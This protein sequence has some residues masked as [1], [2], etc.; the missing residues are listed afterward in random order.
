VA[1]MLGVAYGASIGGVA[2]LVGSPPNAVFAG[3][4]ASQLGV[5]VSFLDWFAVGAPLSAVL[6]VVTWRLLVWVFRPT[7]PDRR[8]AGAT[9][10]ARRDSLGPVGPGERRTLTVFALVAGG[11]LLRPFVLEP[12]FPAVTDATVG[13]VGGVLLFVVRADGEPLLRW[14]DTARLPW[15]VLVLLGAGF[16]LA[17]GFRASGLDAVV[18]RALAGLG[19]LPTAA[20]VV[21]VATTVVFLTEVTSNTATATVFMPIAASLGLALGVSPLVLMAT[22]A[23]A[24]SLAF[25]LP[26]AT[27][28]N[29]VVFAS[30]YVT[31]PQMARVGL[32][33]N[34]LAVLL[35][36]GVAVVWL[37]VALGGVG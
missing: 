28:P 5:E 2:T 16:S 13:V 11:W 34:L 14:E 6:L 32:W 37:P 24:A 30:G 26:V 35:L 27:P 1:L 17:N 12:V 9:L 36:A 21:V 3:V 33:L 31:V 10:R 22:V 23:L 8:A 18:A 20:L 25:M 19:G 7:I 4:A 29:A 15:G